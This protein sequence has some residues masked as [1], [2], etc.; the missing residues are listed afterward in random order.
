MVYCLIKL[1]YSNI[2]LSFTYHTEEAVSVGDI[3]QIELKN[4]NRYGIII[5][6]TSHKG[7]FETKS[8]LSIIRLFENYHSFIRFLAHYYIIKEELLYKKIIF[9]LIKIQ[10]KTNNQSEKHT[11]FIKNLL[12][13]KE[14]QNIYQRIM[15]T[16]QNNP[17][18][19][20]IL[21]G[22]TGS[23]KTFIYI[24]LILF[25]IK[26]KKSVILL[27]PNAHL[28]EIIRDN[29]AE[30]LDT[31]LCYQYHSQIS[32]K[33]KKRVWNA[34]V[35]KKVMLVCGVHLPLFLPISNLGAIIVDEEH[36]AG[37]VHQQYPYINTKEAALIRAKIENLF[38]LLGSA[39]PSIA[40]LDLVKQGKYAYFFLTQR[41]YETLLP[42]IELIT[43]DKKQKISYLSEYTKEKIRETLQRKEQVL[44]YLNKK[45]LH[46]YAQC[47]GCKKI[48]MCNNCSIVLTI[49][50]HALA[51]CARCQYKEF[52]SHRCKYCEEKNDIKTVGI[53]LDKMHSIL[54][55]LFPEASIITLESNVLR[56]KR[57]A[58]DLLHK[59]N[60]NLCDIIVG[61]EV[62]SKGYNFHKISLVVIANVDQ[63]FFIPHFT[64]TEETI[65]TVIQVA[66]R[67]GRKEGQATVIVQSFNDISQFKDY[68]E[69]K[70]YLDFAEYELSFRKLLMLPPYIKMALLIIKS[71]K[72]RE[73][74]SIAN[75]FY[76]ELYSEVHDLVDA[77]K[78]IITEP[79]PPLIKKIKKKYYQEIKIK[80]EKYEYITPSIKKIMRTKMSSKERIY[81]IPFPILSS[82]E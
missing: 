59:I 32:L 53:G 16:Y 71:D 29:I 80:T 45:G 54:E 31:E 58:E 40:S 62:I 48:Y 34:I 82:Y 18:M 50:A 39:T 74:Q 27:V 47:H 61:T 60:H 79:T 28:S 81:F 8:I 75:Q 12:L 4:S 57:M 14:Q 36:D 65:Q 17:K 52:I 77:G 69:E 41:Y 25:F 66:G 11:D 49:F 2:N 76:Q 10:N 37:Y 44:I 30:Y 56:R 78:V 21:H 26:Q 55:D 43:L 51:E 67:G 23:G 19:P 24:A 15:S 38:I 63:N 68:F 7:N 33:E 6:I 3:A 9:N 72:E 70:N 5:E 13:S 46:R 20:A 42:K 22:M 35:E 64:V 1:L 73:G